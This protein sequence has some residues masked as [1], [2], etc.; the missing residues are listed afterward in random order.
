MSDMS[1]NG[2]PSPSNQGDGLTFSPFEDPTMKYATYDYI[3]QNMNVYYIL[4]DIIFSSNINASQKNLNMTT[5]NA[6]LC[7]H[8]GV[9]ADENNSRK[10]QRGLHQCSQN[11]V[12]IFDG[13][14]KLAR[15]M[16]TFLDTFSTWV[17]YTGTQNALKCSH[18]Y[19]D[20][21]QYKIFADYIL[22]TSM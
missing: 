8:E 12:T 7:S 18:L 22:T 21:I 14:I 11:V 17:L 3:I 2:Y 5:E 4:N 20:P 19:P 6:I 1:L 13:K 16:T 15:N 9:P 10:I